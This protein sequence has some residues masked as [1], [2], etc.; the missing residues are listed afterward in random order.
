MVMVRELEEII[1]QAEAVGSNLTELCRRSGVSRSTPQV[2]IDGRG[3]PTLAT[4]NKLRD[5]LA[6]V[7]AERKEKMQAAGL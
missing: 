4:L 5:A 2:W 7:V 1:T 6:A 3:G